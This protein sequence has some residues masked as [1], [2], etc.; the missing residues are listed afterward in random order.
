ME[1]ESDYTA[2]NGVQFKISVTKGYG[3]WHCMECGQDGYTNHE[4]GDH[5]GKQAELHAREHSVMCGAG[6]GSKPQS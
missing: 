6:R 5:A 2:P 1:S 3:K 4:C